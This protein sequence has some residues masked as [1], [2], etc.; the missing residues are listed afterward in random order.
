MDDQLIEKAKKGDLH[1]FRMMIEMYKTYIYQTVYGVLRHRQ[2]AEDIA[3]EAFLKI[4]NSLPQYKHQGFKTWITRIAVNLAIDKQ[5][6]RK[7]RQEEVFAG[8]LLKDVKTTDHYVS[9]EHVAI[10]ANIE[11]LVRQRM[12]ELPPGYRD[13]VIGFYVHDK[14][15]KQ[16]AKE[17]HVQVKTIE[18]KLYRARLWM[19][20]HWKEDDFL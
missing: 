12:H 3:Q 2:D 1:A 13:V 8:G 20:K 19:R 4:Y 17:Q 7:R 5:R 10:K 14:S 15:Y 18:M 16:L 9:A 11:Q 6:K